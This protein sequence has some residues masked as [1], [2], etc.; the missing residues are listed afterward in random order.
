[1]I[2]VAWTDIKEIVI[3]QFRFLLF[4]PLQMDLPRLKAHYLGYG[5]LIAWIVGI[6][7]YWD[8]PRAEGWQ[9]L[10]LG[11]LSYILILAL[12][13]W[14]ILLPLRPQQWTY[15]NVLIF[16]GMTALPGLLYAIPVELFTPVQTAAQINMWFLIVVALWRV[17]LLMR[18]LRCVAKLSIG[19]VIVATFLPISTILVVLT[20][21]NLEHSAVTLMG[22]IA[23][24]ARSVN[25]RAYEITTLLGVVSMMA[26]PFLFF[27]YVVIAYQERKDQSRSKSL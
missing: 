18:F 9:Y 16:V 14:L 23:E 10:G 26:F 6:G 5:I 1:M 8:N 4:Q 27:A 2:V 3:N 25:D 11:S 21:L 22:G 24:N 15:F 7:R 20:L 17:G 19:S 13:L 12:M